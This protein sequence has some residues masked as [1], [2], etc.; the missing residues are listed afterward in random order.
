M[1]IPRG[2]PQIGMTEQT[3]NNIKI[4]SALHKTGSAIM[5]FIMRPEILYPRRR[6]STGQASLYILIC[7]SRF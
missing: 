1:S 6:T 4:F 5:S 2:A 3:S 7:A